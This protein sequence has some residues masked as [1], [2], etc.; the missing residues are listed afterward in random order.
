LANET[1]ATSELRELAAA[2]TDY[3]QNSDPHT[4]TD[5]LA[6]LASGDGATIDEALATGA[7]NGYAFTLQVT[8]FACA[9]GKPSEAANTQQ[10]APASYDCRAGENG[11][12]AV[13]GKPG[14]YLGWRAEAH[15]I[16]YGNTGRSS[17]FIDETGVLRG[18]DNGG[19]PGTPDLPER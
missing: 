18:G 8:S 11:I 9:D 7:K 19:K 14:G 1:A 2:E 15:P 16:H 13:H 17:F 4:F 10:Y 5:S 6:K 12:C 3:N